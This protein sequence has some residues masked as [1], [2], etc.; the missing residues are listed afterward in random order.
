MNEV[1]LSSHSTLSASH[2]APTL[3]CSQAS[4]IFASRCLWITS[5]TTARISNWDC[6]SWSGEFSPQH[7][8]QLSGI[9]TIL[10]QPLH[11]HMSLN[12][13]SSTPASDCRSPNI[14]ID[15]SSLYPLGEASLIPAH[16]KLSFIQAEIFEEGTLLQ[17][18]QHAPNGVSEQNFSAKHVFYS[19][20]YWEWT[21]PVLNAQTLAQCDLCAQK[22]QQHGQESYLWLWPF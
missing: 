6:F 19:R 13:V 10:C 12:T 7:S 20:Y 1:P 4:S 11:N 9:N 22:A 2:L 3:H 15:H 5:Q 17:P 18:W 8:Q 14:T 16:H 21:L